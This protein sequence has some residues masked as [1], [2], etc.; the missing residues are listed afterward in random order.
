[1]HRNRQILTGSSLCCSRYEVIRIPMKACMYSF[2]ALKQRKFTVVLW[3]YVHLSMLG[4]MFSVSNLFLLPAFSRRSLFSRI[5]IDKPDM[6]LNMS[7]YMQVTFVF[8]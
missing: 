7:A 3:F 6:K 2:L 1:M 4:A 8:L 5:F